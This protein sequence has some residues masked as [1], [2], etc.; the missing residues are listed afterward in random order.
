MKFVL[1][2]PHAQLELFG[3]FR[4]LCVGFSHEDVIGAAANILIQS[5]FDG[6][7]NQKAAL[8]N[9]DELAAFIRATLA[10]RYAMNGKRLVQPSPIIT[11]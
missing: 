11:P 2:N 7:K 1:Q 3:K 6:S 8:N 9:A 10:K 4:K 5:L